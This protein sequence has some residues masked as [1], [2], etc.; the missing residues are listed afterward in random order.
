MEPTIPPQSP[1]I[2][3]V[4]PV[5]PM[6]VKPKNNVLLMLVV[7]TIL[8]S[9]GTVGFLVYQNLQLKQQITQIQ[10]TPAPLTSPSPITTS[11]PTP[12]PTANWKTFNVQSA[13]LLFKYPPNLEVSPL[14]SDFTSLK[15]NPEYFVGVTG[16][17]IIYLSLFLYKSNKN[18]SDWWTTEGKNKFEQLRLGVESAMTPKAS[19]KFTYD[20]ATTTFAGKEALNVVVNSDYGSPQTPVQRFLTIVQQ[21]G[22]IVMTSYQDM[23]TTQPSINISKQILSTFKFV[24]NATTDMPSTITDLFTSINNEFS[25]K[26]TPVTENTFYTISGDVNKKSWKLDLTTVIKD[27]AQINTIHT[28]FEQKF[29]P[30]YNNSADGAGTSVQAYTNNQVQCYLMLGMNNQNYITCANK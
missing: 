23:G 16:S 15:A 7:I 24:D 12:D 3:P 9:L 10:P 5:P 8:L 2:Q 21:N 6:P 26:L 30:D 22:F 29:T 27:K 4:V 20:I 1:P 14:T 25:T 18:P 17:D 28:I 11:A 19:I 13:N